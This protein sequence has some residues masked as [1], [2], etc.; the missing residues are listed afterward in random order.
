MLG[1]LFGIT[2]RKV[3]KNQHLTETDVA[4][5]LNVSRGSINSYERGKCEPGLDM[6][7]GISKVLHVTPNQ[8]LGVDRIDDSYISNKEV[9]ADESVQM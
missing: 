1:N 3:R 9:K 7:I 6:L 5:K 8:L 4:N 2:M